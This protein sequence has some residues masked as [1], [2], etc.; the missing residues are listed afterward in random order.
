MTWGRWRSSCLEWKQAKGVEKEP[1]I[2]RV[3]IDYER[4][5]KEIQKSGRTKEG[6]GL[7]LGRSKGY[8]CGLKKTRE[9][10]ESVEKV[11]CI[12]LGL[13]PGSL[14]LKEP[15]RVL[16]EAGAIKE[17]FRKLCE[18]EKRMEI[19]MEYL[20]KIFSKANAN[21][22]QL[23]RI[24]DGVKEFGQTDYEKAVEFMKGVLS[25]GRM[26]SDEIL[27]KSDAAGI[28]RADLMKAKR[29]MHVDQSTTGYGKN[30]K[31]WWFLPG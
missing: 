22:V 3:K 27:L 24:K 10:P 28:K 30:Q 12:L 25:G 1:M 9:Q 18:I 7:E 11:M 5:C 2:G 29:D 26:N 31:T 16:G 15:E 6:F 8:I 14:V 19:Q 20:E 4:L 17:V 23:E 13:E 21:T